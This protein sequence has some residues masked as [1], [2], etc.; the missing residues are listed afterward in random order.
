MKNLIDGYSAYLA[1]FTG[2]NIIY[3]HLRINSFCV[4]LYYLMHVK[5]TLPK[6][7]NPLLYSPGYFYITSH[8]MMKIAHVRYWICLHKYAFLWDTIPQR[9]NRHILTSYDGHVYFLVHIKHIYKNT[10]TLGMTWMCVCVY[11]CFFSW[12]SETFF[13]LRSHF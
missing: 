12:M 9:N 6:Q 10:P 3:P 13:V 2:K 1:S 7:I 5:N 11:A 8:A 4:R